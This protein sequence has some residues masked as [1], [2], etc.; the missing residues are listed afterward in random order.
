M[1]NPV[2]NVEGVDR[3]KKGGQ[4]EQVAEKQAQFVDPKYLELVTSEG[5]GPGGADVETQEI[6]KP[7]NGEEEQQNV[8]WHTAEEGQ[9]EAPEQQKD[10]RMQAIDDSSPRRA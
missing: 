5:V 4:V 9:D 3:G 7:Q 6:E 2:H 8:A 10:N 1:L